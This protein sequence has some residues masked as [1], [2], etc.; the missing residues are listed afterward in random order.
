MHYEQQLLCQTRKKASC[1]KI[2]KRKTRLFDLSIST[3]KQKVIKNWDND[4]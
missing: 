2:P 4:I 1:K 3:E